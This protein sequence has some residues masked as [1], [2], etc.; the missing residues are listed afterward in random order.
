MP[1]KRLVLHSQG[2]CSRADSRPSSIS[3]MEDQPSLDGHSISPR[4]VAVNLEGK[5]DAYNKFL[6]PH[7][8]CLEHAIQ[9]EELLRA[10]GGA[11]VLIICHSGQGSLG[12]LFLNQNKKKFYFLF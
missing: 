12:S 2:M 9:T 6:R 11:K 1:H 10:R 7:V 3:H 5:Q 8:F 4:N